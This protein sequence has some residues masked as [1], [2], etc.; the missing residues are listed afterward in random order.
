MVETFFLS[1]VML[2]F[3]LNQCRMFYFTI[4]IREN[5]LHLTGCIGVEDNQKNGC[6]TFRPSHSGPRRSGPPFFYVPFRPN[7]DV[8]QAQVFFY[9]I[10]KK[11]LGY[12][13]STPPGE[14]SCSWA[15]PLH[16][17]SSHATTYNTYRSTNIALNISLESPR[18]R[19]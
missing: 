13:R 1:H 7:F 17:Y 3:T 2:F 9:K 11:K 18:G 15:L 10:I 14:H 5:S 8:I 6:T 19:R 4:I 16:V 12:P